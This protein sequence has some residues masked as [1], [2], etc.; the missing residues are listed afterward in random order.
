MPRYM[1][2]NGGNDNVTSKTRDLPEG[3]LPKKLIARR[4]LRQTQDSLAGG[5]IICIPHVIQEIASRS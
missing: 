1:G 3:R 4:S 5:L 2:S